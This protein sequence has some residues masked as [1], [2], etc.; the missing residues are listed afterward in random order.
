MIPL[1]VT[2]DSSRYKTAAT[3]YNRLVIVSLAPLLASGVL[4]ASSV[5]PDLLDEKIILA[6]P[7]AYI[8][9]LAGVVIGGL[10]HE[11]GHAAACIEYGGRV[12]EIGIMLD[13][14]PGAYTLMDHTMIRRRLRTI[15]AFA[16][17]IE[18]NAELACAALAVCVLKPEWATFFAEFGLINA[19]YALINLLFIDGL[20][21]M[22][23]M[24]MILG[25]EF[26]L[27]NALTMLEERKLNGMWR[28]R[29][30]NGSARVTA[31]YLLGATKLFWPILIF[32]NIA[33]VLGVIL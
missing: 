9:I 28:V 17:G 12:M 33:M 21:G 15:Q 14:K 3:L 7:W 27:D 25:D 4:C 31:A 23:I 24:G 18:V 2:R 32:V 8:G 30:V 19:E 1:L 26:A 13:S 6:G 11:F 22:A 29:G 16:A 5:I 10:M 20:D